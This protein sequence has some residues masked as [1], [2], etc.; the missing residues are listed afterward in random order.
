MRDLIHHQ[1]N[2]TFRQ[3]TATGIDWGARQLHLAEGGALSFTYLILAAGAKVSYF[4]IPGAAEYALPL[5]TL[6]DA[7]RLHSHILDRFE[8]ADRDPALTTD[9]AFTFVVVGGGPTGVGI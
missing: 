4:G 5:Y 2:V 3:A 6:P 9:G 1:E 7:V 8:A